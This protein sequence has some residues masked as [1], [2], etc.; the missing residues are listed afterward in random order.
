MQKLSITNATDLHQIPAWNHEIGNFSVNIPSPIQAASPTACSTRAV[1]EKRQG[2]KICCPEEIAF[3]F[4]W[5]DARQL[6]RLAQPL[7]KSNYG[8]Y[9][10]KLAANP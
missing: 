2:F 10:L 1:I 6:E 3:R 7:A 8:G 4:G 9:L 5:I